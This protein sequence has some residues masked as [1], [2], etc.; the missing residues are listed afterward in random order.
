MITFK[1]WW[2]RCGGSPPTSFTERKV[3]NMKAILSNNFFLLPIM[4]EYFVLDT[5]SPKSSSHGAVRTIQGSNIGY[6]RPLSMSLSPDQRHTDILKNLSAWLGIRVTGFLGLDFFTA[7]RCVTLDYNIGEVGFDCTLHNPDSTM[8]IRR[9][10][11]RCL[12][13][14]CLEDNAPSKNCLIDTGLFQTKVLS[15][16]FDRTRYK[17]STGWRMPSF[18]HEKKLFEYY[19]GVGG[20]FGGTAFS[21]LCIGSFPNEP[22]WQMKWDYTIGA[23]VLS[24]FL[25][26]FD[27]QNNQLLLKRNQRSLRPGVDLSPDTYSAGIQLGAQDGRLIIYH[28]LDNS[29]NK[30]I[31]KE[32]DVVTIEGIDAS[33]L[34][35]LAR[36]NAFFFKMDDAS[37]I[38]VA[39][40]DTPQ[41]IKFEPLFT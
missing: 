36:A 31:V 10:L 6:D 17:K 15:G 16:P 34:M 12:V 3:I 1:K 30:N 25:C 2:E 39:I 22:S 14:F 38:E 19:I 41:T 29:P 5:G 24:Q 28:I 4:G 33:D 40:N 37:S 32:G 20:Q 26:C 23:N 7:F 8:D 18:S 11:D 35:A 21:D 27:F 13:D 9:P